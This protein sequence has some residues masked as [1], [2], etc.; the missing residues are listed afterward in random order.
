MLLRSLRSRRQNVLIGLLQIDHKRDGV[1]Q[2]RRRRRGR[3]NNA[4]RGVADKLGNSSRQGRAR[5]LGLG[6]RDRQRVLPGREQEAQ[7]DVK[8]RLWHTTQTN[9]EGFFRQP[10][11][12][13]VRLPC[14]C[15]QRAGT[16]TLKR[17]GR[18]RPEP[19]SLPE[20]RERRLGTAV[21]QKRSG[22]CTLRP[23]ETKDETSQKYVSK[24]G[25]AAEQQRTQNQRPVR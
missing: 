1:W 20:G 13:W 15:R 9:A 8:T 7:Q 4:L 10:Q 17:N 19:Q 22:C 6:L 5:R 11:G 2:R 21:R 18:H 3:A 25:R 24:N 16:E 14:R 12:G 23:A